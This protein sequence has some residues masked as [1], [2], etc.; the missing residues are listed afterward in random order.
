M[1]KEKYR[2][3]GR[4]NNWSEKIVFYPQYLYIE[5][6]GMWWW[7]KERKEWTNWG[8]YGTPPTK[9]N[10]LFEAQNFLKNYQRPEK[11]YN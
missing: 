1:I 3:L 9:F 8:G 6:T 10:T 2:V 7:K 11:I 5:K 4:F